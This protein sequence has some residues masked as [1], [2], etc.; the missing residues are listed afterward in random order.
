LHAETQAFGW[1]KTVARQEMTSF[2]GRDRVGWA[3]TF[4]ATAYNLVRLR[5]L[6]VEQWR[7][8]GFVCVRS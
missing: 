2:L 1:I 5:R 7:N 6:I 3:F 4:A 8:S